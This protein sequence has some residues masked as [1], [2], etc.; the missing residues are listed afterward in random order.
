VLLDVGHKIK[1]SKHMLKLF[2]KVAAAAIAVSVFIAAFM[3]LFIRNLDTATR[4]VY[5]GLG[6]QLSE[7]PMWAKMV[8]TSESSWAGLGWYA[9]DSIWFFGGLG[10]AFVL[11]GLGEKDTR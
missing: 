7:P 5:D 9:L 2:S 6:R 3:A 1:E 8:F 11:Y 10:L 4:T